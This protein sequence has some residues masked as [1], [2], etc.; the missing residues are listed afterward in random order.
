VTTPPPVCSHRTRPAGPCAVTGLDQPVSVRR[1]WCAGSGEAPHRRREAAAPYPGGGCNTQ[2]STTAGDPQPVLFSGTV[3][4]AAR[5]ANRSTS[6]PKVSVRGKFGWPGV[7]WGCGWKNRP[8]HLGLRLGIAATSL[9]RQ[10]TRSTVF[11][12]LRRRSSTGSTAGPEAW[13][14]PFGYGSVWPSSWCSWWR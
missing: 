12:R 7:A 9:S 1:D 11:L 8:P 5:S 14:C 10:C 3:T 2:L 4:S 13:T 6:A